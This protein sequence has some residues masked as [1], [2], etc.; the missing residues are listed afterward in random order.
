MKTEPFRWSIEVV[1]REV[2]RG[3]F[4][5]A[6]FD[7]DGTV[8]LIREGWQQIMVP[9]FTDELAA[10]PDAQGRPREELAAE[11]REFIY[12]NTGKQTIYQCIRLAEEVARLGGKALTPLAYK[13][14]YHRRLELRIAD[15]IAE[16]ERD[17]RAAPRHVVPGTF[18]LLDALQKRGVVMYLASGTDEVYV[19]QE[20]ALLSVAPYFA[21]IYGAQDDY[22]SFSKKM[23]IDRIICEHDLRGEELIGFGDGYVEIENIKGVKGFACGVASDEARRS[24]IDEWKR[25]RLKRSGADIII[26]DYTGTPELM[27]Y[28]FPAPCPYSP[29]GTHAL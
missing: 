29:G 10:C 8:S 22:R 16:L 27:D 17:P 24:G 28:L 19:R 5:Y 12:V 15:R 13:A 25:E 6:I 21:G 9:Y 1:R 4:R 26:P 18:D 2:P 23:V 20:A 11:A 14:E 7:F 3:R